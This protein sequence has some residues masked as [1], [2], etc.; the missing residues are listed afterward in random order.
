[1]EDFLQDRLQTRPVLVRERASVLTGGSDLG[2]EQALDVGLSG[3]FTL[4]A[5]HTGKEGLPLH[6]PQS[7]VNIR[8]NVLAEVQLDASGE[9]V[10]VR[11]R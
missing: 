11:S 8:Q 4:V 1:M 3:Y 10:Y 9:P 7:A 5:L 2:A 6:R